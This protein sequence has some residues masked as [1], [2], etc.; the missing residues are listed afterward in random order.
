MGNSKALFDILSITV[1]ESQLKNI[2]VGLEFSKKKG[3]N[4]DFG[5]AWFRIS[6]C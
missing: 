5:A 6:T 2:Q 3:F 4:R 1:K